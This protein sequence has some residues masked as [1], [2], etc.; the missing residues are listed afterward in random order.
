MEKKDALLSDYIEP[1]LV[2]LK[3]S[4][5]SSGHVLDYIH[6]QALKKG[7]VEE[8][9]LERI[10]AR[11]AEFP[12]GIE[13]EEIGVAIPHTDAE[14]IKKEFIGVITVPD[15][16]SFARMDDPT[17][18]VS[19]KIIFVLGLKEP[20]AQLTMLQSLISILRQSERLQILQQQ[21]EV[22]VFIGQIKEMEDHEEN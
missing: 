4:F 12:T 8:I 21:T 16:V 15:G 22:P 11:E 20:H 9:F 18:Y 5:E 1:S 13:L 14:C 17:S 6:D 2:F 19:A 3:E 10:K 7:Y